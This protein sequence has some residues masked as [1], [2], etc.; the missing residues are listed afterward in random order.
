MHII[1][2]DVTRMKLG[3][4]CVAGIDP[5]TGCHVR[6]QLPGKRISVAMLRPNGGPFDMAVEVDLGRVTPAPVQPEIEDC[7]VE[8]SKVRW[9]RD[10][11]RVEFWEL[12]KS[13]TKC[14]LADIFGDDFCEHKAKAGTTWRLE[15]GTG[16]ASLGCLIPQCPPS[17]KI[18]KEEYQGKVKLRVRARLRDLNG[19]GLP[20]V[21]DARLYEAD[22]QQ[23]PKADVIRDINRRLAGGATAILSVGVTRVM[24]RNPYHWFQVNNIHLSDN[25]T[26]RL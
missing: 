1:V 2:S 20:P 7:E 3:F 22:Q 21:T 12:L 8:V 13:A 6:P 17:L 14:R 9:V 16:I 25:P 4:V 26:W 18:C 10:V 24:P 23:T 11:P 15:P 19:A 5:K